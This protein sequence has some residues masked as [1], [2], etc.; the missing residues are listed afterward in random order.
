MSA[1]FQK[2]IM[3]LAVFAMALVQVFGVQAGFFC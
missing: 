3:T 1:K 2:F